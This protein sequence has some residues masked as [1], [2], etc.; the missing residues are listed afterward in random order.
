[1]ITM[2]ESLIN[3][4]TRGMTPGLRGITRAG[5]YMMIAGLLL[6]VLAGCINLWTY[7]FVLR[8]RRRAEMRVVGSTGRRQGFSEYLKA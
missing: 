6:H 2:L 7:Y 1:M 4:V 5:I 8:P 3:R